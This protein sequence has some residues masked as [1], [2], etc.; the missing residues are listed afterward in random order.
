[1]MLRVQL[2]G[3]GS[4]HDLMTGESRPHHVSSGFGPEA[5]FLLLMQHDHGT[6]RRYHL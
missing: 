5:G 1:M 2:C 4:L 6:V 3:H